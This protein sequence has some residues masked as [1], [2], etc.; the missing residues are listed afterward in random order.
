MSPSSEFGPAS[1]LKL[2]TWLGAEVVAV[3]VCSVP[4]G[5]ES[6]SGEASTVDSTH[7]LVTTSVPS[8]SVWPAPSAPSDSSVV[9][10]PS[11][12]THARIVAVPSSISESY[13]ALH[14]PSLSGASDVEHELSGPPE[15]GIP[16]SVRVALSSG[17]LTS[18]VSFSKSTS[19]PRNGSSELSVT[20]QVISWLES[21]PEA[22]FSPVSGAQSRIAVAGSCS[23]HVLV[24]SSFGSPSWKTSSSAPSSLHTRISSVPAPPVPS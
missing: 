1:T 22:G 5:F 12:S 2:T 23:A 20:V 15:A 6:V 10:S 14:V 9:L 7:V 19:A 17:S 11:S 24:T 16:E 8:E 18:V 3:T 13:V 4:T 21:G